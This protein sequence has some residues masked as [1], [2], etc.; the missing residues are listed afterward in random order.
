MSLPDP[1]HRFASARPLGTLPNILA[2]YRIPADYFSTTLT[3]AYASHYPRPVH[4]S[5]A[6]IRR[7][8]LRKEKSGTRCEYLLVF[9]TLDG[10]PWTEAPLGAI[11][12]DRTVLTEDRDPMKPHPPPTGQFA[13][14]LYLASSLY[15]FLKGGPPPYNGDELKLFSPNAVLTSRPIKYSWTLYTHEYTTL[16][17]AGPVDVTEPQP[18][19]PHWSRDVTVPPTLFHLAAAVSLL[20]KLQPEYIVPDR[21]CFWYTAML[22]HLLVGQD[23]LDAEVEHDAKR[24]AIVA[25]YYSEASRGTSIFA[26]SATYVPS[27]PRR[28]DNDI[29]DLVC[30][31]IPARSATCSSA[32]PARTSK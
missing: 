6:R 23:A 18:E 2:R 15:N 13:Y 32:S 25:A 4:P 7:V 24:V 10:R 21:Q 26:S 19:F 16:P 3:D 30:A 17:A 29:D 9:V 20:D 22:Y 5:R 28:I 14:W 12:C 11:K 1:F 8:E 27:A 31:R